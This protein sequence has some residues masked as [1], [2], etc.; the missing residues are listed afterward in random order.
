MRGDLFVHVCEGVSK[1]SVKYIVCILKAL[2]HLCHL[3][4]S[5]HQNPVIKY[6]TVI[7]AQTLTGQKTEVKE[8]SVAF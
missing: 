1:A 4:I 7:Q 6:I 3:N 5:P 2:M 8:R